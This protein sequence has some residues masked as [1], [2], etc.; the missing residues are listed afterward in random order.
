M[1]YLKTSYYL[2]ILTHNKINESVYLLKLR[3]VK[4]SISRFKFD[5][6]TRNE[7]YDIP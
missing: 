1:D 5:Y 6:F 4:I 2:V 3:T 7:V